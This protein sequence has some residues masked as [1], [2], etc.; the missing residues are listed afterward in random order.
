MNDLISSPSPRRIAHLDMDMFFAGVE[1]LQYPQLR[2]MPVVVGGRCK[3]PELMPDGQMSYARLRD[4]VGRGVV[5][6]STY[7]ARA[8][9]VY[10]AMGLMKSAKL[11]PD[12]ILLPSHFDAYKHYSRLFKEAVSSIAPCIEDRGIDEIYIDLTDME[13]DS[14]SL[15]TAIKAAVYQAT[16]LTCSICIAPNKL[17][18][19]IGSE[20]DKPDGL[21]LLDESSIPTRIWPLA[22]SKVNGIGPKAT[23]KLAELGIKT[24][25]DLAKTDKQFL[26]KHF[27]PSSTEWLMDV[28]NGRDSRPL[29]T[30]SEPKS[31][32]RETTFQADLHPRQDKDELSAIFTSLC[33]RVAGDLNRKG[34]EGRTIG[35]KL[36]FSDFSTVTRDFSIENPTQNAQTIRKAAGVCLKRIPLDKKLRLL[37]V[38]VGALTPLGQTP[39]Q[40][41]QHEFQF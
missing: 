31:M 35:V 39:D 6:T 13:Q 17:L 38:R 32:S 28:A 30:H 8:L 37:G 1:L 3:A 16:N 33:E 34:Y 7:E 27:S 21:T 20:L 12:A 23:Q 29:V 24:V 14:L 25:G 22:V 26:L 2:G 10:S 19:K 40:H 11:A 4:Y 36:R 18:A 5:T 15:A 9:G 41:Q